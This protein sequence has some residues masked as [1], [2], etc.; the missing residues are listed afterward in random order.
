MKTR[1]IERKLT[2]NKETV[3]DLRVEEME[4]ARGGANSVPF[5]A[6]YTNDMSICLPACG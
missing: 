2:L 5:F 1:K 4:N 3:S 6:C